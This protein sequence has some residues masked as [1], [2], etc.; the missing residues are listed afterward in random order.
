MNRLKIHVILGSTR[1]GR[2]SEKPGRWLCDYMSKDARFAVELVD[3]RDWPLPFFDRATIPAAVQDGDYGDPLANRWAQKIAA[4]DGFVLVTPE[5]NHGYSAVLKNALDWLYAE[6][7]RKPVAFLGYGSVAGVRAV[8]QL[9]QVVVQL[10]MAPIGAAIELPYAVY[11]AT[12]EEKGMPEPAA[13][14]RLERHA[15]ALC[16]DLAWW[17]SVLRAGRQQSARGS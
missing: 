12:A 16:D 17:A 7:H 13:F 5:Y 1:E 8:E 11:S 2:Y 6:W 14:A 9:R 4:A 15:L 10:Q 3:L